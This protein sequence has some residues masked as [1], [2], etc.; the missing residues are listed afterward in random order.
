MSGLDLTLGWPQALWGLAVLPLML[1]AVIRSRALL[2]P[3]MFAVVTALRLLVVVCIV[4][5]LAEAQAHWSSDELAVATIIDSSAS[6]AKAE[7]DTSRARALWLQRTKRDISWLDLS[8]NTRESKAPAQNLAHQLTAA[9]ALLPRDRVRRILLATDGRG[10]QAGLMP[11]LRAAAE[12]GVRVYVVPLG[13][14]PPLDHVA[15][16]GIELPR[17]LRAGETAN[18][19]VHLFCQE[20]RSLSLA[21]E[22]DGVAQTT[23][24]LDAPAGRSTHSHQITFRDE[25][26]H[27][28]SARTLAQ[29]DLLAANNSWTSLVRVAPPPRVL[30]V[31]QSPQPPPPLVKVLEDA[32]LRVEVATPTQVAK[33]AASLNRFQLVIV[34]ETDP[35]RLD[36][37][38]QR[39][40]KQ[41]VENGGGLITTTGVNAVRSE[42]QVFREIEPI[43]PP[44]AIPETPPMEI[45][46][47]IDR[48]G[49][50]SGHRIYMARQAGVAAVQSMRAD[51]KVGLVAFSGSPDTVLP[52]VEM[53]RASWLIGVISSLTS[54]GGTDISS[55]LNA[56]SSIMSNDPR[57]L[58]H[59]ILLSD[60]VS[61]SGPAIWEAQA[62][63]SRGITIS[64]ISLGNRNSLMSSIASIGRGRYHVAHDPSQLP[65]LFVREA[66]YRQAPPHREVDFQ[67]DVA[68]TM[69]FLDGVD[70]SADPPI[71]GYVLA[72]TRPE[73]KTLL[74]SP[75][76]DPI[77]AH[78]EVGEGQV[79]SLTTATAGRWSDGWRTGA[80]F[81]RLWSQM[82]WQMLRERVE[83]NLEMR[84][85]AHPTDAERRLITIAS[86]DIEQ[87]TPP[88]VDLARGRTNASVK[89]L[90]LTQLGP[91]LWNV[92]VDLGQ[93]FLSSGA[94]SAGEDPVAAVAVDNP[95]DSELAAFGPDAARLQSIAD[96]GGG[97]VL[98]LMD[99]VAAPGGDVDTVHALR[100]PLLLAALLLYLVSLLLL[101]LPRNARAGLT[102]KRKSDK[103]RGKPRKGK[104]ADS[105][106]KADSDD[107][108]GREPFAA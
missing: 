74:R 104:A 86:N 36:E 63:A 27:V 103:G 78:W 73:A 55:A 33:N 4:L 20:A 76:G 72:E 14:H 46:L 30:L 17:L 28:V 57:Y 91:G 22:L 3:A 15:V 44:R 81:R 38:Q 43:I 39:A 19:R 93:G 88:V 34:D 31:R 62:L 24:Q 37:P 84:V 102:A 85:D 29:G 95:Y 75:D 12:D 60:G 100:L 47:V 96:A 7:H 90:E 52:P 13:Q 89:P 42:P 49:S 10:E 107:S 58:H 87:E 56:A 94:A 23:M 83:A 101:R 67:P 25:G 11:A 26:M 6:I 77:L 32:R 1:I 21:V 61:S 92:E 66:R 108:K 106:T 82:A 45:V 48:S 79:A 16:T 59:I 18:V 2:S 41:W 105:S 50:M 69:S 68:E 40:I 80:S 71:K 9:Q 54:G 98:E 8:G 64:T 51:S 70:F 5:A 99:S 53:N 65:N 97:Q 35:S